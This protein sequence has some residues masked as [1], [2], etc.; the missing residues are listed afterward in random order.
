[1]ASFSC[2][3][4]L[5]AWMLC[6]PASS[7]ELPLTFLT[8]RDEAETQLL[9][10]AA[11]GSLDAF[12]LYEAVLIAE[13]VQD[14]FQRASA[15]KCF[16]Q[17]LQSDQLQKPIAAGQDASPQAVYRQ[18]YSLFLTGQ[19]NVACS[20][21]NR[22]MATGDYN[23]LTATVFF[24]E[25]AA[26]HG[27]T[28]VP[29]ADR[30]HVYCR[31]FHRG[32]WTNVQTT[33]PDWNDAT[34]IGSHS[35]FG[36]ETP[37]APVG[38]GLS[39]A[40]LVAKSFYNRG[41]RLLEQK[42]FCASVAAFFASVQL[43]PGDDAAREN[44]LAALNNWSLA[45]ADDDQLEQAV[46]VVEAGLQIDPKH[47]ALLDNDL[48]VHQRLTAA[49]C[50]AG[51]FP[52][53]VQVMERGF[54]RRPN[55]ALFA[56]G[57]GLVYIQWADALLSHG[58]VEAALDVLSQA[59]ANLPDRAEQIQAEQ[60]QLIQFHTTELLKRGRVEQA[61]TLRQRGQAMQTGSA[62]GLDDEKLSAFE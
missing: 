47:A 4:Y 51:A 31:V 30:S 25:L 53:A 28:V 46:R 12:T 35:R 57:R 7:L 26:N 59:H 22:T 33:C 13:G 11:D 29:L 42:Q 27:L 18:L 21:L 32:E 40:N 9:E 15:L 16:Q 19:Y 44:L 2:A 50:A 41:V 54:R 6:A 20:E 34:S 56:E 43:D 36:T 38:R 14:R 10:D 37:E 5:S 58:R 48:H 17:R 3:V 55:V 61:R 1:M 8:E 62:W 24:C 60:D 23:C 39:A 49:H 52:Q 45:L